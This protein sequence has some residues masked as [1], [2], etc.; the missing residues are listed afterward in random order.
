MKAYKEL[1][2]PTEPNFGELRVLKNVSERLR[3]EVL[4][5]DET[6]TMKLKRN[7][8]PWAIELISEI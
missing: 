4:S 6:G 2:Y 3:T 1:G 8:G 5:A 7:L